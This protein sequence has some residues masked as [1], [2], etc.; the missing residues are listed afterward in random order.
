MGAYDEACAD[1]IDA[2]DWL[3]ET[4]PRLGTAVANRAVRV[5]EVTLSKA[6]PLVESR[7]GARAG[8][9]GGGPEGANFAACDPVTGEGVAAALGG[10]VAVTEH[11]DVR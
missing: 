6:T 2:A 4:A 9:T 1:L 10:S 8:Q 7:C 3:R 11:S 5:L